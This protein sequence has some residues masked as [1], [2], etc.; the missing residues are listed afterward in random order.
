[1][2]FVCIENN[3]IVSI[4]N[5]VPNVPPSVQVVEITD[6][7]AN[8]ITNQTH[9]FDLQS[10]T[11]KAVSKDALDKKEIEIKNGIEREYLN[12]TDW[13]ILRHMRQ[14][15]LGISTSMS[16]DQ[17]RKLEQDRQGAAARIVKL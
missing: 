4:L 13:M 17:F 3:K 10:K 6:D 14:K 12:S 8:G 11:V 9:Y 16:E 15:Y 5:Y 1:M 7:Q 2:Y